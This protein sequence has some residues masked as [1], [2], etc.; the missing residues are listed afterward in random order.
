MRALLLLPL[1]LLGGLGLARA[2]GPT[3]AGDDPETVALR[4]LLRRATFGPRAEDLEEA[5]RMGRDAWLDRQ[6]HPERI[7]DRD[8]EERLQ[9]FETLDLT[10][11]G[12]WRMLDEGRPEMVVP[13]PGESRIDAARRRQQQVNR[14]RNLAQREVPASVLVRAVSSRR[15]LQEVMV[16]FWRNHFN[17][18]VNKGDV[19]YYLPDWEREVLRGHVFGRFEDFLL[20]T[21]R[22]PAMLYYLDNH[23]SQA[24]MARGEKVLAGREREDRTD[25]L[26]ENYARELMELHT[27]GVD[28]GYDQDDV[29]QLALVL[30]GW[31]ID[32]APDTRGA[33]VFRDQAHAKGRKKVMGKTVKDGGVDEGEEVIRYLAD[34]PN[35]REFVCRKMVRYLVA[36]D[37]PPA[38]V[39]A[40]VATWKKTKGDLR[41][42]VRTILSDPAFTEAANVQSKARTPLEFVAAMLRVTGA[43]VQDAGVLLGRLGDMYQAVYA[44]EDP[45]GY[46]DRAVDW[47]DPGVLAVRWQLAWDLMHDRVPGVRM[48]DSPLYLHV[49]QNPEVWESLLVGDLLVGQT[50][51]SLT[52]A[53]FRKRVNEVRREFRK[54]SPEQRVAEFRV[55][56]T[57]LLGSPEFQRQ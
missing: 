14:L 10:P 17:V 46:S 43:N 28:N 47:M 34:H 12:Y 40:A 51:G 8:V 22:H 45:T 9:A 32:G 15:Q 25:G 13:G 19:R 38:L 11:T 49:R 54:M 6:L 3:V 56:V 42:V 16:D 36:D 33:F 20:A 35:T 27:V 1:V 7:P 48:Q 31:S 24:P 50:P 41:E 26:N 18:D 30:T 4:H 44:C 2:D 37:P 23:V 39:A 55:L 57:L 5:K 21:A 52:M 29:I 53:P